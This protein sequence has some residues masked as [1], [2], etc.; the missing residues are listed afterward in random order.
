MRQ[1]FERLLRASPQERQRFMD[2][3]RRW[4]DLSPDQRERARE[5]W[6]QRHRRP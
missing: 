5:A 6:R 3:L 4:R 1:A 2:N